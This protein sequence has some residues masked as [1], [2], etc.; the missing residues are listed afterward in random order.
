MGKPALHPARLIFGLG[1][2]GTQYASTRHNVGFWTVDL[3]AERH[4]IELKTRR[5]Q[6][7]LGLGVIQGVPVVLAKPQ[8]YM[9][10]SGE[11]A[12]ALLHAYHLQ[13]EQMLVV[14]DDIWL[15]PGVVRVRAKGSA[16][17][18]NGMK[19]IISALGT[20]AFPR[21]RIGIGQPPETMELADYVLSPPAPEERALLLTS[22]ERAAD[23]CEAWLTEPIEQVMSRFN[24][25]EP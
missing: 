16:G 24:R 7:Q 18:H 3:L 12:R 9:N 22:V 21:V 11:A 19:S 6:S 20:E 14:F 25:P 15:A 2:P 5:Y 17:G 10:L 8:T 1:N 13:P 23:A 4:G